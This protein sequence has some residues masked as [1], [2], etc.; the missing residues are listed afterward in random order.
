MEIQ[1]SLVSDSSLE[2]LEELR[3]SYQRHLA[4]I[5]ACGHSLLFCKA[6]HYDPERL[7]AVMEISQHI[8]RAVVGMKTAS[9]EICRIEARLGLS[10][11]AS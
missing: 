4:S 2:N 6:W 8:Q 10:N 5:L 9:E 11:V 7:D 3:S 1:F